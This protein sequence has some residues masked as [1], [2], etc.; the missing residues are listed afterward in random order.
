MGR[1]LWYTMYKNTVT[2]LAE[3]LEEV[4]A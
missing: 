3:E 1:R 4:A 2:E